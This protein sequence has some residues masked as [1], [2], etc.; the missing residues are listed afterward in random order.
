MLLWDLSVW[1][2]LSAPF[3][4]CILC[5]MGLFVYL[6][7]CL[8]VLGCGPALSLR[9]RKILSLLCDQLP[10]TSEMLLTSWPR[11]D[12]RQACIWFTPVFFHQRNIAKL[13]HIVSRTKVLF[14]RALI[15]FN[16][17]DC[18]SAFNCLKRTFNAFERPY[19][20]ALLPPILIRLLNT[21]SPS[22]SQSNLQ[23]LWSLSE[24]CIVR[25][26][27]YQWFIQPCVSSHLL[28]LGL[29]L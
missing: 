1:I 26:H 27:L 20:W 29:Q 11:I 23:S 24:L 2:S 10:V 15:L 14:I 4:S 28:D 21:A 7:V 22:N 8:S 3:L 17:D 25:H 16:S 12:F 18:N 5:I 9:W 13:R 6:S 19:K